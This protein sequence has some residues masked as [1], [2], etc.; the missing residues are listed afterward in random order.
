MNRTKLLLVASALAFSISACQQAGTG[1]E[2]SAQAPG[3]ELGIVPA[4]MDTSVKP[5]DDFFAFTNGSWVKN[6]PIPEDRSN[7]GA[8]YIADQERERQTKELIA[9]ILKSS[10]A[11]DSNEGKIANYYNAFLNTDAIDKAGLNPAKADLDAIG[12]IADKKQLSAAIG[13]TLRADTDPLNATNFRTENLFGIFVTQG[14]NTPGET[15]PYIMQGGIGLPEREYYLSGDAKMADLRNKYRA[16]VQQIL[17]LANYPDPQG[18][19]QRIMDLETKIARAHATREESEDFAK[20]AKVWTRAELEKNAPGL[21]WA[22]LLDAAQLGSAPKFQA[23]H[24]TAIPKLSALVGSEPIQ[25]WKDWLAFHTLNQQ[26]AV[27]PKAFRDASFT[28]NGTALSGTPKERPRDQLAMNAV[29]NELPDAVGKVYVD[30]YFP[31]S[32]KAEIQKMVE[33]IKAAFARRVEALD[34]MAPSTK[35]EALKKVKSIVVGVGYPDTWRDYSSL[36]IGS[37]A[38]AN[39]KNARLAEY[40]HQIAKIGKPMDRAEWWMPPQLVNAVNLPVQNALNFPAAI[41]QRP[42]FDP[43]ADPAFNYGA[44]GSVIGHEI[45]HSFDNNGALFDSTGALRNWWTPADFKRFQQAGDALAAQYDAYEALPGLHVNG[46]LTLGENIADVAGLSAAYDAYK[47]SL[48]GKEA[49]VI[50]GYS[51][52]QRFFIAYG[53]AWATKMR[54]EQLRQRI[55]TDGHAPGNFRAQ[56]VRNLDP[57]YTAFKVGPGQK[58]YLAP[59]K[60]VK[61]W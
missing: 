16:Y 31:V 3:T 6:T 37:D 17:T 43:K 24:S 26:A 15:L 18:S 11:A 4:S 59:E 44:I 5:G 19:A 47:H 22:A 58:L 33:E 50:Q 48:N 51:G 39:Q 2:Q 38:Y 7:I 8:F 56:T 36:T 30:K 28:F 49:P 60:R 35:E 42:F 32:S 46:K 1:T 20:G 45:S 14:L 61:V 57:W 55:A 9:G 23:Y 34:W 12:R 40:R 25:A 21:D 13:G 54:D 27:L 52:D 53:Q 10:P 29:S 41:L